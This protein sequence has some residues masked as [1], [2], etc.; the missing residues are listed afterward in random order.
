MITGD[1][2]IASAQELANNINTGI[3]PAP[4][5]LTSERTIDAKIGKN[6]LDQIVK[7]GLI[8]LLAIVILLVIYYRVAGLLAG[9][10]LVFYTAFL[11]ALVKAAGVTLSLAS[12]A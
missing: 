1:Y 5:Y 11:I 3:V 2:T 6:A 8:G 12:I 4:I 7:A 9:I 10:A